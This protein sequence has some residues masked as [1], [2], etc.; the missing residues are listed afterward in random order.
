[1]GGV[2]GDINSRQDFHRVLQ[3]TIKKSK[4]LLARAPQDETL[5]SIDTQ[6]DAVMHWTAH[7]RDPTKDQRKSLDM[8]LR[9][10]RELEPVPDQEMHEFVQNIYALSNYVEDWPTDDEAA[11]AT[12]DDYWD[13]EEDDDDD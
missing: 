11:N 10:V 4:Q 7:G 8:G 3:E 2:Y 5:E 9:A 1:M 13:S 6:L 12:D